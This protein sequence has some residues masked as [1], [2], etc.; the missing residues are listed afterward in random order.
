MTVKLIF[1]ASISILEWKVMF[2][3]KNKNGSSWNFTGLPLTQILYIF[4]LIK[5]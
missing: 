4:N 2:L 3:A 5:F 1:I